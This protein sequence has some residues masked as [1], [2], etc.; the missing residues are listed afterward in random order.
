M[1]ELTV[2]DID[3]L[4]LG[5]T[6]LGTGGGGLNTLIP[7]AAAV[8]MGLPVVDADGMRRAFPQIE[9]TV[10]TLAGLKAT[11]M[12]VADEK[13]NRCVFEATTNLVA[14][15]LARAAV[16]QLGMANAIAPPR[17]SLAAPW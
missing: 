5:A 6:L 10:F 13:G 17:V 8:E 14:E 12:S 16:V 15:S 3:D 7:I 11:P 9:M 4:A 1:R 2:H